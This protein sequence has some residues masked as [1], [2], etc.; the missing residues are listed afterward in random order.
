M[1]CRCW[2]SEEHS[3][4]GI[5]PGVYRVMAAPHHW[6]YGHNQTKANVPA[7]S[8]IIRFALPRIPDGCDLVAEVWQ[9]FDPHLPIVILQFSN[10]RCCSF[11]PPSRLWFNPCPFSGLWVAQQIY[12]K[13]GGGRERVLYMLL[14]KQENKN[15]FNIYWFTLEEYMDGKKLSHISGTGVCEC[16][17]QLDLNLRMSEWNYCFHKHHTTIIG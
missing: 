12:T 6:P 16:V 7:V 5:L 1:F 14:W 9:H 4:M 3:V 11:S 8:R 13:L 10:E 17:V 15:I 2:L